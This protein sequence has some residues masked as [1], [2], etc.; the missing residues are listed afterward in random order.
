MWWEYLVEVARVAGLATFG[1]LV[2]TGLTFNKQLNDARRAQAEQIVVSWVPEQSRMSSRRRLNVHN[3]SDKPV[4]NVVVRGFYV[5][6][7]EYKDRPLYILK[8]DAE[9]DT[10][11]E[12]E[13]GG[14]QHAI[15]RFT[16]AAW[17]A[18]GAFIAGLIEACASA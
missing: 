10:G 1:A 14:M 16:D 7:R 15:A 2:F 18:L 3:Y 9:Y 5:S 12:S 4:F 11:T 6:G 8:P 13:G 17:Q